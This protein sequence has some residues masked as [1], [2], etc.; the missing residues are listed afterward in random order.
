VFHTELIRSSLWRIA[1]VLGTE[2]IYF[3]NEGLMVWLGSGFHR[4]RVLF[5]LPLF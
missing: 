5:S 1:K 4:L 3:H 2:M